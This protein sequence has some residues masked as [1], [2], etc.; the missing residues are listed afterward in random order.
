MVPLELG[1]R[2]SS[3]DEAC[4]DAAAHAA[5][6]HSIDLLSAPIR[7]LPPNRLA[8]ALAVLGRS[9]GM[10]A[11][12]HL[13]A[14]ARGSRNSDVMHGPTPH[15]FQ[16]PPPPQTT[17][18]ITTILD[19]WTFW[20]CITAR[21]DWCLTLW[22]P[23][24]FYDHAQ[25][26]SGGTVMFAC[27]QNKQPETTLSRGR[28]CG[29]LQAPRSSLDEGLQYRSPFPAAQVPQSNGLGAHAAVGAG[30]ALGQCRCFEPNFPSQCHQA[31][32]FC[33]EGAHSRVQFF[34][35]SAV[36]HPP[37][38]CLSG[39]ADPGEVKQ[40]KSSRGSVETTRTR[41]DPQWVGMC[42]GERQIGAAKG[43]PTNTMAS[44][45]TPP[46]A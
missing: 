13:V 21:N 26:L 9:G 14:K 40:D 5:P 28:G 32:P 19:Y 18:I 29:P 6:L 42:S 4:C 8:G 7:T 33:P 27:A 46:T 30:R 10:A 3:P 45:Q 34:T 43:K 23:S 11:P 35:N 39:T 20:T 15:L 22:G 1:T 38:N 41:L 44:C 31:P 17:K 25:L 36:F 12:T 24:P 37:P 16:R 2:D